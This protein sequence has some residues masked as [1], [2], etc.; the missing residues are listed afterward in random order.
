MKFPYQI[1]IEVSFIISLFFIILVFLLFPKFNHNPGN[2][3]EVYITDIQVIQIPRTYQ[4]EAFMHPPV[5]KPAVPVESEEIE[6][7]DD[8]VFETQINK[9]IVAQQ[10]QLLPLELKQLPYTP[11][12][13]YEV[14]PEGTNET[15]AGEIKLSLKVDV[16]GKVIDYLIIFNSINNKSD[17][18]D[19]IKAALRSRWAPAVIDGRPV[20]YWVEKS[21]K[22]R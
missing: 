18:D 1:R 10:G 13:L 7:L 11:R 15:I 9:Q 4:P 8:V 17:R 19:V 6:L 12:Q 2:N 16:D 22:F 21:Y 3:I 5:I 14:L 20:I